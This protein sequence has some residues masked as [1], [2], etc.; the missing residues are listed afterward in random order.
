MPTHNSFRNGHSTAVFFTDTL[1]MSLGVT[2]C[3]FTGLPLSWGRLRWG[4]ESL[5]Y[6]IPATNYKVNTARKPCQQPCLGRWQ[7]CGRVLY[8]AF[9]QTSVTFS[10]RLSWS[11]A[12]KY[13]SMLFRSE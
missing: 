1:Q 12:R 9:A 2:A 6:Y 11:S 8:A 4:R 10:A 5:P 3:G 13:R 7:K